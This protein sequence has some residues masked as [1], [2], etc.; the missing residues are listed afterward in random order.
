MTIKD[1]IKELENYPSDTEIMIEIEGQRATPTN[2]DWEVDSDRSTK[3]IIHDYPN[4]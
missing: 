1:L 4:E 3:V 2:V